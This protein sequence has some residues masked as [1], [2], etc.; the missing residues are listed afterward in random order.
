MMP[1]VRGRFDSGGEFT[2]ATNEKADS[3]CTLKWLSQQ[4]WSDKTAGVIG[5]SM[6]GFTSWTAYTSSLEHYEEHGI[7]IKFH[8]TLGLFVN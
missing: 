7:Q 4:P 2:L 8:E 6:G 5:L 1:L 3:R